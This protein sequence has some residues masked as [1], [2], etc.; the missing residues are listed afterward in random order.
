MKIEKLQVQA[1]YAPSCYTG[2][3]LTISC[4]NRLLHPLMLRH[5][6]K[7]SVEEKKTK[8]KLKNKNKEKL[9]KGH[10]NSFSIQFFTFRLKKIEKKNQSIIIIEGAL[11]FV[12]P[13]VALAARISA[14][15]E[16]EVHLAHIVLFAQQSTFFLGISALHQIQYTLSV[17][18][19]CNA[20][21]AVFV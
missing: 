11:C 2:V 7:K 9:K 18:S 1:Q 20:A 14:K 13:A 10:T 15:V 5:C 16:T 6:K 21:Q 4:P 17:R 3:G 19:I 8:K 12:P